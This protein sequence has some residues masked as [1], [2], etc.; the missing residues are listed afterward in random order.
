[1]IVYNCAGIYSLTVSFTA[2]GI[3]QTICLSICQ[4]W[5]AFLSVTLP[6]CDAGRLP[7]EPDQMSPGPKVTTTPTGALASSSNSVFLGHRGHNPHPPMSVMRPLLFMRFWSIKSDEAKKEGD[8]R[9]PWLSYLPTWNLPPRSCIYFIWLPSRGQSLCILF[10]ISADQTRTLVNEQQ[11]KQRCSAS[12]T[13]RETDALEQLH[14]S[15]SWW[16]DED[17]TYLWQHLI[18]CCWLGV[19]LSRLERWNGQQCS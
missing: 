14:N 16:L 10:F 9:V 2:N 4:S 3:P 8:H 6:M 15:F 7:R 19:I 1:M 17:A 13:A 11:K 5:A 18:H 12:E